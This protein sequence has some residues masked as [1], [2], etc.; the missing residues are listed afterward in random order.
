M[1]EYVDLYLHRDMS[2]SEILTSETSLSEMKPSE[3]LTSENPLMMSFEVIASLKADVHVLRERETKHQRELLQLQTDCSNLKSNHQR[4]LLKLQTDLTNLKFAFN[5]QERMLDF[6]K[7][8]KFEQEKH[9]RSELAT[10]RND[11]FIQTSKNIYNDRKL[12]EQQSKLDS[13]V[14]YMEKTSSFY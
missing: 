4:E 7:K 9:V 5:S 10:L 13:A 11:L 12:S 6:E 14:Q 8:D 3:I 2:T 1:G